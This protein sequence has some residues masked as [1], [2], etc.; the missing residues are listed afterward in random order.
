[1]FWLWLSLF[2]SILGLISPLVCLLLFFG[3]WAFLLAMTTL[4]FLGVSTYFLFWIAEHD[5]FRNHW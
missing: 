5:Y 4:F 3:L 2:M 1:M